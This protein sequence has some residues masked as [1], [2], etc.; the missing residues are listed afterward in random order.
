LLQ[1]ITA[2]LP[3]RVDTQ[4]VTFTSATELATALRRAAAAH[5]GHEERIGQ[6][7][8][9]WADWYADYPSESKPA[10]SPQHD[11]ERFAQEA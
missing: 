3:G 11:Y 8:E 10:K 9:N 6:R 2:R 5:G 4:G 1:E 7:D